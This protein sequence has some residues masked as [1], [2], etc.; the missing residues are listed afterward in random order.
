MST[1]RERRKE[2]VDTACLECGV[3]TRRQPCF[4]GRKFC[5]RKCATRYNNRAKRRDRPVVACAGCGLEFESR[6]QGQKSCSKAC[7]DVAKRVSVPLSCEWCGEGYE[8]H[9]G[10]ATQSKYCSNACK[11]QAGASRKAARE[12]PDEEY[13]ARLEAQGGVCAL[14]GQPEV[15]RHHTGGVIRL[16][17]DHDHATGAWRGLLCRRCNMALGMFDD[18]PVR[19]L[20]AA[21]YVLNGGV[22]FVHA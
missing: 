2:W 4:A 14:C 20:K 1:G 21:D 17:K 22:R 19:L 9:P 3:V 15:Q 10:K 13:Q 16:T 12:M 7:A 18:D 6:H 8:R 5:D 11:E